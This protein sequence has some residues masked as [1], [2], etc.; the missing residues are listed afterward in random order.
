MADP[1]ADRAAWRLFRRLWSAT[2]TSN[3]A[4]G[5]LMAAT[6]LAALTLTRD[7]VAITVITAVQY[8]PWLL[9][10][11]PMGTLADR[12]D[13][14][15][16]LRT[17]SATRA[18]GAG[19]L[20]LGLATGHVHI[21]MLYGLAF[22][23]GLAETLY[24]N[25]SSALVPGIVADHQLERANGRLLASYTL[26]NN[27]VGP[28]LGSGLF[29]LAV[30]APF[31]FGSAGYAVALVL[32]FLLPT[33]RRRPAAGQEPNTFLQDLRDGIR[34]FTGSRMLIALCALFGVGN[35]VSAATYSLVSLTVVERLGAAPAMFGFVL[36]GGAVGASLGGFY[37]DRVGALTRPGT[38]LVWTTV[39]SGLATAGVGWVDNAAALSALMALDGFV[40]MTQSVI[41]ASLRARLI[42]DR[43]LGRV[44]AVFR[45]LA[46]GASAVGAVLGGVLAKTLGLSWPFYIGGAICVVLGPVLYRWLSNAHIAAAMCG[47]KTDPVELT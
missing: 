20:A 17:A 21:V 11:I 7:P 39:V 40:V 16:L 35:L 30:A 15:L 1:V 5:V 2:A 3:V 31:A 37:G 43:M 28:P 38:T 33:R 6:Q 10:S 26:A 25:T 12:V 9:L 29:A 34:G 24:D 8:L 47:K 44:T 4:D 22:V 18:V 32:M 23:F 13:R 41:A 42:P 27:F 14:V 19:I 36:A 45:T 46:T